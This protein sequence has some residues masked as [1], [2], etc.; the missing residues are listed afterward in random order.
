MKRSTAVHFLVLSTC[1]LVGS[2]STRAQESPSLFDLGERY[3]AS[4]EQLSSINADIVLDIQQDSSGFIW[5]A[6][7]RGLVRYDGYEFKPYVHS[8]TDPSSLSGD[9]VQAIH[10][11]GDKMWIG[12][13]SDGISIYDPAQDSFTRLQHDPE[14]S[15]SLRENDVR[16]IDSNDDWVLVA[17]R[18]GVSLISTHTGE[19]KPLGVVDGCEDFLSKGL[20]SSIAFSDRSFYIG[21]N[22]GLCE[23]SLSNTDLSASLL[24]GVELEAFTGKRVFNIEPNLSGSVW[25]STTNSGIAVIEIPSGQTRWIEVDEKDPSK[26]N[27]V[28]IDDTTVVQGQV[29]AATAGAGIAVIDQNKLDVVEHITHKLTNSSGLSLNDVSAIFVD[30][31]GLVWIGTWGAGMNLFN[32]ANGAFKALRQNP[33]D[34]LALAEADIRSA[35]EM[36][37]GDVWLGGQT[38]GVQVIRPKEGLVKR[39]QPEPGTAGALQGGYV[40]AFEQSVDGTIWAATNQAGLFR[41]NPASDSFTQFTT[42]DGLADDSVRTLHAIGKDELWIGTDAGL[43]RLDRSTGTFASVSLVGS[44]N[45][46]FVAAIE[47]LLAYNGY[48]WVGTNAGLFVIPDDAEQLIPV[49][50]R[51]EHSLADNFIVDL[52]V[53]EKNRLWV[54]SARGIDLLESWDG[55]QARFSSVNERLGVP[56][57]SLGEAIVEDSLGRLWAQSTLIDPSTWSYQRIERSSGWDVG[58]LWIGSDAKLGDGTILFGGTRGLQMVRPED[59]RP[60]SVPQRLVITH[61]EV[62]SYT[63]PPAQRNPLILQPETKTFSVEFSSLAFSESSNRS[64]QYMLEGYDDGWISTDSRNRRATYSRLGPGNY[65]LKIRSLHDSVTSANT[66]RTVAVRQLPDWYQTLWFRALATLIVLYALYQL[67]RWQ[68]ARL[69]SQKRAL[70]TLVEQRT[71]N[72][73]QLGQ[74]GQD[75]AATLDLNEVIHSTYRHVGEFM[76]ASVYVMGLVSESTGVIEG[77]FHYERDQR[78]ENVDRDPDDEHSPAAWCVRNKS[79][80]IIPDLEHPPSEVKGLELIER[81]QKVLSAVFYPLV[82][83]ERVLG[84]ISLQSFQKAAYSANELEMLKTIASYAAVAIENARSHLRLNRAKAELEQIS[85][86]DQLTGLKNR[87]FLESLMPTEAH[88]LKR[89]AREGVAER[90]GMLMVDAD[91]FKRVNDELGHEAGDQVLIQFA[92]VIQAACRDMD[93]VVRFGGEEFLIL[94]RVDSPE[95]LLTLAERIRTQVEEYCFRVEDGESLR[96]TCSIGITQFPFAANEFAAV[97]WEE[98]IRLA[99][100]ALYLSKNSGRNQWTAVF[101]KDG[102]DPRS[103]Y[104]CAVDNLEQ[105]MNSQLVEVCVSPK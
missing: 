5:L 64:Y 19:L 69:E 18:S 60:Q 79:P 38:Q 51:P 48:L 88:R 15:R 2:T 91:H 98:S 24:E 35:K 42:E 30:R 96:K 29:W 70:D 59:Y 23:V 34:R 3:F 46:P 63:V 43:T 44:T 37:N 36:Q 55:K 103:S 53:D 80:L 95:L 82:F 21:S 52:L 81:Q 83:N 26:L 71:E 1:L 12:T 50:T 102:A 94:A 90:L 16:A 86:T 87:R 101:A 84:F 77:V 54:V 97:G 57:T 74:A 62:D 56:K 47:T 75:I 33:F 11:V 104:V 49:T 76:D 4:F 40:H 61:S 8:E 41:F 58:N 9:Y 78:V 7:Q 22:N 45:S 10:F 89:L 27:H 93:W 39:Y 105:S 66:L 14:N 72:I 20:L 73:R 28:W 13:Y 65:T 25:V 68:V 100:T 85:V 32:P 31:D 17:T 92:A 6:T 67:F 99:D